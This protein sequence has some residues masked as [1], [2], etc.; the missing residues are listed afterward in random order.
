MTI[1]IEKEMYF[2]LQAKGLNDNGYILTNQFD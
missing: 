1:D 2:L